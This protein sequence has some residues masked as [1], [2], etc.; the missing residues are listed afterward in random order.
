VVGLFRR[1][2]RL[3]VIIAFVDLALST[4]VSLSFSCFSLGLDC[5]VC[6][7]NSVR[8]VSSG[9]YI[10]IVGQKLVSRVSDQICFF[11]VGPDY[12][13]FAFLCQG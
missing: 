7:S 12:Y 13:G 11:R 2:Q 10:N 8:V 1:A 4:L 5:A 3:W 6:P 9:C